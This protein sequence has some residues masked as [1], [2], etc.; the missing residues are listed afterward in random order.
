MLVLSCKLYGESL[1][2]LIVLPVQTVK[3]S[4]SEFKLLFIVILLHDVSPFC[5]K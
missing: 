5:D 1:I 4:V 2:L 3:I